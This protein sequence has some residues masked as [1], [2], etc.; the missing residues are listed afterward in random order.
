MGIRRKVKAILPNGQ[1]L[2]YDNIMAASVGTGVNTTSISQ[3]CKRHPYKP[4]KG[5]Y[6]NFID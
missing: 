1:E 2:F 5:I 6:F 4:V 3:A